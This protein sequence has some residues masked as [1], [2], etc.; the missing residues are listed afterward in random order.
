MREASPPPHPRVPAIRSPGGKT[1]SS[2][3]LRRRGSKRSPLPNTKQIA[4][5]PPAPSEHDARPPAAPVG[6]AARPLA[7]WRARQH[8]AAGA[9][10]VCAAGP[11][12]ASADLPAGW[13]QYWSK[14]QGLPF[15]WFSATGAATWEG[16]RPPP[17]CLVTT[18]RGPLEQNTSSCT[19]NSPSLPLPP[20]LPQSHTP[21]S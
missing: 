4:D 13:K 12:A 8:V 19:N 11:A 1:I 17:A 3:C 9:S 20:S 14:T 16:P 5:A 2:W 7:A 10:A 18:V 15:Y 6:E 21:I